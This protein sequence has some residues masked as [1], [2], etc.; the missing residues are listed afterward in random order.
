MLEIIVETFAEAVALH[1][2]M[3]VMH[4]CCVLERIQ[5]YP[6]VLNM[7]IASDEQ[8]M[9]GNLQAYAVASDCYTNKVQMEI[10]LETF[11][12]FMQLRVEIHLWVL[13]LCAENEHHQYNVYHQQVFLHDQY[14]IHRL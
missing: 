2:V 1:T 5:C 4:E 14:H 12:P 10:I 6:I 13:L 3:A 9:Q 7:L 8:H 11:S